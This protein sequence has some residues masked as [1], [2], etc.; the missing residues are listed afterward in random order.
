[1]L[2]SPAVAVKCFLVI[3]YV[4]LVWYNC[5]SFSRVCYAGQNRS[6]FPRS[7]L[8][9]CTSRCCVFIT[10]YLLT[11]LARQVVKPVLSVCLFPLIS[12]EP[13]DFLY[14]FVVS[15]FSALT[16]LVGRQEEHPACKHWL[17]RYWCGYLSGARCRLFAY[18]PADTTTS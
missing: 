9:F 11:A 18:G 14:L 10:V 4:M 17:M 15:A 5:C 8:C 2:S 16:L 3:P 7:G 6:L 12:F 13:T 1:M